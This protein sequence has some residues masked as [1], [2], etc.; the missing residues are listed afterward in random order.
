MGIPLGGEGRGREGHPPKE[1]AGGVE[2]GREQFGSVQREEAQGPPEQAG[3][4]QQS[5]CEGDV[6]SLRR[7]KG[8]KNLITHGAP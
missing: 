4:R 7:R 6:L 3:V 1:P 8:D 2:L 5:A